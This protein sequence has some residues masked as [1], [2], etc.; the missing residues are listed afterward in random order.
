MRLWY[1]ILTL[2]FLGLTYFYFNH[3]LDMLERKPF[4][5]PYWFKV[6]H[7]VLIFSLF[8]GA[9]IFASRML[10]GSGGKNW[11]DE[12]FWPIMLICV[13]GPIVDAM[14]ASAI[15]QKK[16]GTRDLITSGTELRY[17]LHEMHSQC[18]A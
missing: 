15:V 14:F 5:F 1:G 16:S 4:G 13:A 18:K 11:T 7:W 12:I 17:D 3:H 8:L 10:A 9:V 6:L 2:A